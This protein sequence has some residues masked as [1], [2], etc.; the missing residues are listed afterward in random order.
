M[1]IIFKMPALSPTMV[2]GDI[3][4]WEKS[5][6]D[7]IESG[8]T[9]LA[10]ETDKAIMDFEATDSGELF[11]I[12]IPSGAKSILVGTP[13][14]IFKEPEDT[15]QELDTL[16][17][18]LTFSSSEK[19]SAYEVSLNSLESFEKNKKEDKESLDL[20]VGKTMKSSEIL[21]AS[22]LAKKIAA[23]NQIDLNMCT[24]TGPG[25][26]IVKADVE[27]AISQKGPSVLTKDS[28]ELGKSD[29]ILEEKKAPSPSYEEGTFIPFSGMRNVIA[30]RLTQ[31]KQ[32]I[33]HF[34]VNL[35]CRMD[36]MWDLRKEL[37]RA[38]P[39]AR[40]SVNDF[41][42]K[43][44]AQALKTFP[45]MN[46]HASLQGIT[47]FQKVRLAFAVSLE[48]GLI[49][50]II[51]NAAELSLFGLSNKVKTLVER[52]RS[53]ILTPQEYQNGTFTVSNL[54]MFQIENFQAIINPPQVGILAVGA[55]LEKPIVEKQEIVI[56]KMMDISLSAD[57]RAIDGVLAAQFI[58]KIQYYIE[59]PLVLLAE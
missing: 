16:I 13:L 40:V 41:I 2:Q 59:H 17:K 35:S 15:V 20:E 14:A 32:E 25:G 29:D 5:L 21:P 36:A 34:Y 4:K 30:K 57:H 12:F 10:I 48:N 26:R 47:Q 24:G 58:R 7:I 8:D 43:A 39:D 6:G 18:S 49:T 45:Q 19:D 54:G 23:L 33:P 55:T 56:A 28:K 46:A 44:T 1:S 52:A 31:S 22:P 50:P 42:L 51:E 37:N 3:V 53:G 9:L 38:H 27:R 11:H